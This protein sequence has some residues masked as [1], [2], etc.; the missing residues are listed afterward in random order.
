MTRALLP[1]IAPEHGGVG[2]VVGVFLNFDLCKIGL[3]GL[4]SCVTDEIILIL[5]A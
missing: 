3:I 1:L 4:G 5:V 2:L